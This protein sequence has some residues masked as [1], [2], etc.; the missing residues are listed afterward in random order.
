MVV[1]ANI[2]SVLNKVDG[3]VINMSGVTYSVRF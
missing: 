3:T 1:I 2:Y